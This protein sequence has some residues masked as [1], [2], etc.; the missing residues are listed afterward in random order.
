MVARL[1]SGGFRQAAAK[2]HLLAMPSG[3]RGSRSDGLW[4]AAFTH[5][6]KK[7]PR[8]QAYSF[9]AQVK[10]VTDIGKSRQ[11]FRFGQ[12]AQL[13]VEHLNRPYRNAQPRA[14]R[15]SHAAEGERGRHMPNSPRNLVRIE[16]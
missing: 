7:P 11:P 3:P 12:N 5:G 13:G 9:V 6:F 2:S 1:D 15:S 16:R 14:Q 8:R 10:I 4:H